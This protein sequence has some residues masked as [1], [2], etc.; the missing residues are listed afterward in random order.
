MAA[1]HNRQAY[2][3]PAGA[4]HAY[5]AV[6]GHTWGVAWAIF[7]ESSAHTP[8][9]RSGPPRLIAAD[10]RGF[11][12][13]IHNLHR[14]TLGVAEHAIRSQW[15]ALVALLATRISNEGV[16]EQ[17]LD[18]LWED[19]DQDLARDWTLSDLARS[20]QVGPEQL[21]RLCLRHHQRSPVQQVTWL[22]IQRAATLLFSQRAT[23]AEVAQAVGYEN[24]F[25]FSTAFKRVLGHPPVHGA[26]GN[27]DT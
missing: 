19:V 7:I 22:G 18:R 26:N 21:R 6:G 23:V 4:A 11:T 13:A 2:V 3:R 12:D 17:R 27:R 9:V 14:E 16:L 10:P 24:S 15:A 25:S 20:A 5:Q 1:L 8:N